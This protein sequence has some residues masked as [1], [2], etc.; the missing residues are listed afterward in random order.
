M[1]TLVMGAEMV[2][3]TKRQ[4]AGMD[5]QKRAIQGFINQIVR[6]YVTHCI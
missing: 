4:G 6:F 3:T 2:L 1:A 5:H